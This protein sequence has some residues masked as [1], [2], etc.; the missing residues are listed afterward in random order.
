M[1]DDEPDWTDR[2]A[3]IVPATIGLVLAHHHR[4]GLAKWY[5]NKAPHVDDHFKHRVVPFVKTAA[6][7]AAAR[8]VNERGIGPRQD[9]IAALTGNKLRAAVTKQGKMVLIKNVKGKK[10]KPATP[11]E[12]YEVYQALPEAQRAQAYQAMFPAPADTNPLA[13]APMQF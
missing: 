3:Y 13:Q 7:H 9:L 5:M 2:L 8:I 11:E 10:G 1:D 6:N 12:I 4:K